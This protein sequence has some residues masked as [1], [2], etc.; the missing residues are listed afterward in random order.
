MYV[1]NNS[2]VTAVKLKAKG[3]H[4]AVLYTN[5]NLLCQKLHI[6][7]CYIIRM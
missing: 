7:K 3:R 4:V 5:N 6:I 1:S 2:L